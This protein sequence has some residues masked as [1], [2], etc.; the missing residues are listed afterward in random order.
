MGVHVDARPVHLCIPASNIKHLVHSIMYMLLVVYYKESGIL[1][2][3]ST[4]SQL[5]SSAF[6]PCVACC[7]LER[8]IKHTQYIKNIKKTL[9]NVTK[10]GQ[11]IFSLD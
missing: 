10:Q 5:N 11:V 9:Y 6:S 3:D 7:Y 4:D 2:L 1:I 8:C